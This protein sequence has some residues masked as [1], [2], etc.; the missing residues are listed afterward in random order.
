MNLSLGICFKSEEVVRDWRKLN[1]EELHNSYSSSDIIS[2]IKSR[3]LRVAIRVACTGGGEDCIQYFG[4]KM[5][6][7]TQKT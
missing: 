2:V 5:E 4:W 1:I 7:T 3:R 6:E